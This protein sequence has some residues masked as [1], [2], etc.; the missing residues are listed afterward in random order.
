MTLGLISTRFIDSEADLDLAL[1]SLLP[2]A[3]APIVAYPEVVSSGAV[4]RLIGLLSHENPDI[5][6][7]VVEVIHELT[8]EDVGNEGEDDEGEEE[9]KREE[10]LKVL[11]EGLVGLYPLSMIYWCTNLVI[12]SVARELDIGTFG[13]QPKTTERNRRIRQ[14]GCLPYIGCVF[15]FLIQGLYAQFLPSA[16]FENFVG[17]NADLASLLITKTTILDWLLTRIQGKEN[18]ENRGY[19]AELLSILLQNNRE[20]RLVLGKQDGVEAMLKVLS[21]SGHTLEPV[22][23]I[24]ADPRA[25]SN[26]ESVIQWTLTRRSSWKTFLTHYALLLA[27][28]KIRNSSWTVRVL[29]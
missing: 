15:P 11:M 3:Q 8:D 5:V 21:V 6:I 9:G 10:A 18:D 19:A 26:I 27:N 20:N 17:F 23:A 12:Y 29:I 25:I 16:I 28:R 1:K 13:G 22:I 24:C 7:D 2:L 14:T 4:A